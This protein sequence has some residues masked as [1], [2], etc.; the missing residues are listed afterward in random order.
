[1]SRKSEVGWTN[2]LYRTGE[3]EKKHEQEEE[4]GAGGAG[5]ARGGAGGGGA[6]GDRRITWPFAWQSLM[7]ASYMVE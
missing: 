5:G 6:G 3:Q 7:M 1:M 2:P 4:A